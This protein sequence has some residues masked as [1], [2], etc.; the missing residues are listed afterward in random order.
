VDEELKKSCL[1]IGTDRDHINLLVQ[2]VPMYSINEGCKTDQEFD[3]ERGF[4]ELPTG[5]ETALG[6][7][8]LE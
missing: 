5:S 3:N 2:S 6:R 8:V 1:E 4:E 7:E